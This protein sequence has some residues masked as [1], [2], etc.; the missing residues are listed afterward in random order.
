MQV[1]FCEFR[2]FHEECVQHLLIEECLG[3]MSTESPE[4]LRPLESKAG[5]THREVRLSVYS[6]DLT[7]VSLL[8]SL[9]SNVAGADV[10]SVRLSP[11]ETRARRLQGFLARAL[12]L[13]PQNYTCLG[14]TEK[15]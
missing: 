3:S 12:P 6:F 7:G 2:E 10:A 9:G 13:E 11:P 4:D 1:G 5:S 14:H 15:S 8:N